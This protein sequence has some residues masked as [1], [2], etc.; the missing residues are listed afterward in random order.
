M[1]EYL[2]SYNALLNENMHDVPS[3]IL[4]TV[5]LTARLFAKTLI[6]NAV[7]NNF[8]DN[9]HRISL[10]PKNLPMKSS[11]ICLSDN[12]QNFQVS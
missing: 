11:E 4:S 2:T 9:H 12:H 5:I 7:N 3:K 8:Q 10:S 6:P 1:L